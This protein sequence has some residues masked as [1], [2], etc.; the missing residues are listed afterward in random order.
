MPFKKMPPLYMIWIGMRGRCTNPKYRQWKDYGG[1]G[2]SIC[3]R[4]DSYKIFEQDMGD[5]PP[6]ATLERIDNDGPYS[7]ENCKWATRKE[8]ARNRRVTRYVMIEGMKYRAADLAE[9]SGLKTDTI[10]ER[11][12]SGLTYEEVIVPERRIFH[13]GLAR[14][15]PANG[16]RQ[17]SK[18]HCPKGHEY[19][20]ENT[21]I[22]PQGWRRC[23]RCRADQQLEYMRR[24]STVASDPSS[25]R[26]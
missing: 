20:S 25:A 3:S 21:G 22:S 18:T 17:Q 16:R 11:A 10:L 23:R 26:E 5:R 1:R 13:E 6:N 19:S 15:G 7:P 12:Q 24:K 8:Q 9:I 14:G 4:W 2:I